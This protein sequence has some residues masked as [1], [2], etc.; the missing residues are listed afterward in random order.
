MKLW[1]GVFLFGLLVWQVGLLVCKRFVWTSPASHGGSVR[2]SAPHL[3]SMRVAPY[4]IETVRCHN[5]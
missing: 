2:P 3:Q 4:A 1:I 5:H